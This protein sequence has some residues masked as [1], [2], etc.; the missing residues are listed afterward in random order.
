MQTEGAKACRPPLSACSTER[1]ASATAPPIKPIPKVE[2]RNAT[3][4]ARSKP[5]VAVGVQITYPREPASAQTV[6]AALQGLWVGISFMVVCQNTRIVRRMGWVL[7]TG[8]SFE[9]RYRRF[10]KGNCDPRSVRR[11]S[12][13]CG[14]FSGVVDGFCDYS[15]DCFF[16]KALAIRSKSSISGAF[17]NCC[18][19]RFILSC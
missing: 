4:D 8:A 17:L 7:P 1:Y 11:Q 3:L 5:P 14:C 15:S 6:G 16:S 9:S 19:T 2:R 13:V 10:L 18:A 12:G